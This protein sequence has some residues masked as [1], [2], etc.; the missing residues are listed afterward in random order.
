M[1]IELDHDVDALYLRLHSG[2]VSRTV[3]LTDGVY[4]DLDESGL[5]LGVEFL[6]VQ[7]FT[8]V[9]GAHDGLLE[10]PE[11]FDEAIPA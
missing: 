6:S 2:V 10:I 4:V 5:V 8:R 11:R 3:E 1:K 7:D 9:V